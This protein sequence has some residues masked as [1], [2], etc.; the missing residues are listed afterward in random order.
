MLYPLL[1][2]EESAMINDKGMET[3]KQMFFNIQQWITFFSYLLICV[4]GGVDA[5]TLLYVLVKY[6]KHRKQQKELA[7]VRSYGSVICKS[8]ILC[9]SF[10]VF[11]WFIQSHKI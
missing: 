8:V 2:L 3:F 11:S 10:L 1:W 5:L 6:L 4:G 9:M 7:K